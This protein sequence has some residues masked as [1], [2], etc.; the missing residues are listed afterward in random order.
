MSNQNSKRTLLRRSLRGSCL[1]ILAAVIATGLMLLLAGEQS[2]P[3][4]A[5]EMEKLN[6]F[7]QASS[8]TDAAMKA[9]TEGRDL[10][11]AEAWAKAARRFGDFMSA[12]PKHKNV[13]AAH[14]WIAFA[15]KKQEKYQEAYAHLERL[16]KD[17]PGSTWADDAR[18]MM[19]ELAPKLNK[20]VQV[21][22]GNE[23]IKLIALQSL[24][25]SNPERAA[26]MVAEMFKPGSPQSTRIKETAI[27]LLGQHRRPQTTALLIDLARNQQDAKLR[28]T[29]VFWLGQTN[30]ETALDVLKD[31]SAQSTDPEVA[32]QAVFAISQHRSARATELLSEI[33]RTATSTKVRLQ[34]IFGL[35]QRRDEKAVDELVKIYDAN[36]NV[37]IRNQVLFALSQ[38][39]NPRAHAKLVQ[40]AS[41]AGDVEVRKQAIFSISQH[42]NESA[43]DD[44]TKIY[45][46]DQ[47][48]EIRKQV[49]F[50]FSQIRDPR[51]RRQTCPN[52]GHGGRPRGTKAGDLRPQPAPR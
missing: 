11:E 39:R 22:Q 6:R 12:N 15:L 41:T 21:D 42:R 40:I 5:Q 51:A 20:E 48:V 44:L 9:F 27:S 43:V 18:A 14:Y 46:A 4:F 49:L 16:S 35:G 13:D 1:A 45:D 50:A 38:V 47:N 23:E 52:C 19:I 28:K 7:V 29:A 37:E 8:S 2:Q 36:Q 3:S 17:H 31:I 34:A 32:N 30:D 10:I 33:A 26:E 25:Q 24:F